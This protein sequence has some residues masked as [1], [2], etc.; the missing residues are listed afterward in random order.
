MWQVNTKLW[1]KYTVIYGLVFRIQIVCEFDFFNKILII[2]NF[3]QHQWIVKIWNN[4]FLSLF[5]KLFAAHS[6]L[7]TDVMRDDSNFS[8]S[9]WVSFF[10][11]KRS[12]LNSPNVNK[13]QLLEVINACCYL[14][15]FSRMYIVCWGLILWKKGFTSVSLLLFTKNR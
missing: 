3:S 5:L 2:L 6:L 8:K 7:E 13:N 4:C 1:I 10:Q 15:R 11:Q 12:L 9:D 14:F